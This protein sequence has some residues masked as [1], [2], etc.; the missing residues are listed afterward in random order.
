MEFILIKDQ[1]NNVVHN[2]LANIPFH[3]SCYLG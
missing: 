2:G 1:E 3:G